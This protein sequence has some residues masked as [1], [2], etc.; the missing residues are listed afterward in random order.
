MLTAAGVR[1]LGVHDVEAAAAILD[2]D[3]VANVFVASRAR[4]SGFDSRRLGAQLWGYFGDVGAGSLESLCYAGPNLIPVCASPLAARAFADLAAGQA[5]MCSSIVGPQDAVAM[6]WQRL[7]TVWSP[8]RDVRIRQP[9]MVTTQDPHVAGDPAVRRVTLPE[10]DVLFPAAVQMYAEEV[11]VSPLGRDGG[12]G[13]RSRV[14]EIIR[15]GHSFARI[16]DGEVVF[17]AEVGAATPLACQL[18][19]VWVAPRMRGRGIGTAGMA[20]V[21]AEVLRTVAPVVSLYVNAHNTA[22]RRAYERVGFTTA[23]SFMSVLF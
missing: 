18:Q 1:M 21:V 4:A 16:D 17:K 12:A 20:S 22:A 19:G 15:A 10:L 9:L 23:G 13:Y 6:L 8:A 5:R 3:P 11:G 2:S 7:R 14:L